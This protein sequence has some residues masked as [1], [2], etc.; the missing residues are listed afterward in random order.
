M[1]PKFDRE[2]A[3]CS[4][5]CAVSEIGCNKCGEIEYQCDCS[6]CGMACECPRDEE[7]G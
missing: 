5:A 4:K 2:N 3:A 1:K 7:K 6:R